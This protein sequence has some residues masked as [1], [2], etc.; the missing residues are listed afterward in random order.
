MSYILITGVSS[1][2]GHATAK[3]FLSRGHTVFG[4]VRKQSDADRMRSDF[5][6]SYI[7]L[8]FDTT[9][10]FEV[11]K[12]YDFV[13]E[14]VGTQGLSALI[15]NA[16]I[17][18]FG[19]MQHI[20][21]EEMRTQ[22]EV[23]VHAVVLV[24]QTFLPLL[25]ASKDSHYKKKGKLF[26][27]SSVAGRATRGFLG[28]YAGSKHAIE[29]IFDAYRRE[30]MIYG[31]PVVIIEPGPIK[32][33][34]WAK[35]VKKEEQDKRFDDTDYADIFSRFNKEIERIEKIALPSERVA[36]TIY[37]AYKSKSPK[38]RYLIT[39][40]KFFVWLAIHLIPDKLLDR[41][42]FKQMKN[43]LKK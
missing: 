36:K 42:Q 18:V 40:K 13:K 43:L 5:G 4:S 33:D 38:T 7:P 35:A 8:I 16:G 37:Q 12:S 28:P 34:I 41:L 21:L 39:P 20:S 6:K 9:E 23:N 14:T 19:P 32:T 3:Y 27:I 11:K 24:T 22:F 31:I 1:G 30:L 26:V 29:G 2:I 25:G 10:E 15:N 17:A